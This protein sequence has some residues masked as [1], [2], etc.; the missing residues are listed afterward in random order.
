MPDYTSPSL[1][2]A[3]VYSITRYT[4]REPMRRE[5]L[6]SIIS[7]TTDKIN[8]LARDGTHPKQL[9]A[10]RLKLRRTVYAFIRKTENDLEV[11]TKNCEAITSPTWVPPETG[12]YNPVSRIVPRNDLPPGW[13][14][15]IRG[16]Q[17]YYID[18]NTQTTHKDPP[19]RCVALPQALRTD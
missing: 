19:K 7:I 18:H 4:Q 13:E 15:C 10:Q 2:K 17:T 12:G 9:Y 16:S 11:I 8:K 3:L 6:I 14:M 5:D 1:P